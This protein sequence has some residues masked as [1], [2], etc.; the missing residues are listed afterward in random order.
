MARNESKIRL[1]SEK[2]QM[3]W[4][5]IRCLNDG[6]ETRVGWWVLRREDIRCMADPEDLTSRV[7]KRKARAARVKKKTLQLREDSL[8]PA[9]EDEEMNW[10]WEEEDARG[11]ENELLVSW[12][13]TVAGGA[14]GG[15]DASMTEA[16]Q[17]E[18]SK[19]FAR[20]RCW[21]EEE[22]LLK[23][24][25][26]QVG[27]SLDHEANRWEA[28]AAA[29]PIDDMPHSEAVGAIALKRCTCYI[30]TFLTP[31]ELRYSGKFRRPDLR[32]P[33]EMGFHAMKDY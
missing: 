12:I 30:R 4:E 25:Y 17:V 18:W 13:W 28:H 1:H 9:E 32:T 24:E 8:L 10:D 23:E 26:R 16:L 2:Y 21:L 14:E 20:T 19:A 7:K 5:A 22:R 27:I 29:I 6:D 11:P 3:V 15:S 33:P 31:D